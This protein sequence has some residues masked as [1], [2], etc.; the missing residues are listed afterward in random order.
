MTTIEQLIKETNNNRR[1]LY[2]HTPLIINKARTANLNTLQ[3]IINSRSNRPPFNIRYNLKQIYVQR[4]VANRAKTLENKQLL[5][6]KGD[7]DFQGYLFMGIR[8]ALQERFYREASKIQLKPPMILK[9][10]NNLTTNGNKDI[11][12]TFEIRD[13]ANMVSSLECQFQPSGTLVL[14]RMDTS[15]SYQGQHWAT[16]LGALAIYIAKKT[17]VFKYVQAISKNVQRMRPGKRP[18]SA[19]VLNRL[20]VVKVPGKDPKNNTLEFHGANI[21]KTIVNN[22]VR[23]KIIS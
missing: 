2:K 14:E 8:V 12:V 4:Y 18:P 6:N 15:P 11:N 7:R 13:G 21:N 23:N 1:L 19:S 9:V 3:K 10:T 5:Y 20:G 17:G 22:F 16:F